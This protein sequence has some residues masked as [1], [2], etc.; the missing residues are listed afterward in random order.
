LLF[1]NCSR[2]SRNLQHPAAFFLK[3]LI[4]MNGNNMKLAAIALAT[5]FT[6]TFAYAQTGRDGA[7]PKRSLEKPRKLMEAWAAYCEPKISANMCRCASIIA[8]NYPA[9][10]EVGALP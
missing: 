3:P 8:D 5:A 2:A 9:A 10:E 4:G 7:P 6:R 1:S